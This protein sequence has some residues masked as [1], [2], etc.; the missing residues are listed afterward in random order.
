MGS[1]LF[2]AAVHAGSIAAH[3]DWRA[4]YGSLTYEPTTVPAEVAAGMLRLMDRLGL[5]YGAADLVVTPQA[6][7][8]SWR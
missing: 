5:R 8:C 2:A 6:N 1:Q 4:D 3:E 7:T